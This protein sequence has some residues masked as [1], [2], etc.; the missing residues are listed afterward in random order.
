MSFFDEPRTLGEK[1]TRATITSDLTLSFKEQSDADKLL[2]AGF[3][4]AGNTWGSMA[5]ALWRLDLN[6]VCTRQELQDLHEFSA[7][8][9]YDWSR[10]GGRYQ[11]GAGSAAD[12]AAT[13]LRW[14]LDDVCPACDG[15][16]VDLIP[17]TRKTGAN[18]CQVC[19]GLGKPDVASRLSFKRQPAGQMLADEYRAMMGFIFG[20]M[21]ARLAPDLD[22][23]DLS[24]V[25]ELHARLVDLRSDAAASEA[26][27]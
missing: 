20:S 14:W 6:G 1:Y 27:S 18:L 4:A 21:A 23:P 24:R 22:L 26:T 12:V 9:A 17:G 7:R 13:V 15:R 25:P 16:K 5:L 19:R 10:T 8:K 2:A 11:L 3:A